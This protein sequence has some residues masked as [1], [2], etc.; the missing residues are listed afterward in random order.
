VLNQ[1]HVPKAH[2]ASIRHFLDDYIASTTSVLNEKVVGIYLFGSV[3]YD[4]FDINRSDL[5]L[6]VIVRHPLSSI[7]I[8]QL[9]EMHLELDVNHPHWEKRVEASYTPIT[10]LSEIN[11]P[12]QPRP[13]FGESKLWPEATYGHEWIINLYLLQKHGQTLWG[14]PISE[15]LNPIDFQ[16]VKRAN[17]QDLRNEWL[18][19]Q[20]DSDWLANHHYQSYLVLNLCRILYAEKQSDLG[21]KKVAATWVKKNYPIW[22]ELVTAA[23]NWRYGQSFNRTEKVKAFLQFVI[24]EVLGQV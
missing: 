9:A 22:A 2:S 19:K 7:E 1:L 15:L 17:Q 20:T 21:S 3:T 5:D 13:Y 4:A 24:V 14:Q 6:Q 18:P 8:N 23:D 10:F 12:A 16:E 11:P